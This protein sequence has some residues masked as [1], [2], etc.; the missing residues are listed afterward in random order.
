MPASYSG[1]S[2]EVKG[3]GGDEGW[4]PF[5][6]DSAET[7]RRLPETVAAPLDVSCGEWVVEGSKTGRGL[8]TAVTPRWKLRMVRGANDL[9]PNISRD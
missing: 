7:E 2:R 5:S 9:K 6:D 3:G 1:S 8:C 4:S